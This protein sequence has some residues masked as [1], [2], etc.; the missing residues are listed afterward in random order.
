MTIADRTGLRQ[1]ATPVAF[2]VFNRPEPTA[3][4]FAAIAAVR[5]RQLLIVCDGA[6]DGR[7]DEA[8][9]VAAVRAITTAVDWPCEVRT[10]FAAAN[11][12]CKRRVSSGLDW[13]FGE[14][15]RAIILEDDCLPS[16]AFFAFCEAMLDRYAGDRR[17]HGVSGSD[18]SGSTR[19]AGHYYSNFALMWGWATWRDRWAGYEVDPAMPGDILARLW[20]PRRRAHLFW[21]HVFRRLT[22]GGIDTWD[23]QWILAGWRDSALTVRPTVNLVHNIGF[24]ADATH[25]F[26]GGSDIG[27]MTAWEGDA[28]LLD[29]PPPA[30]AADARRDA[31]DERVWAGISWKAVAAMYLPW[32]SRLKRSLAA[33]RPQAISVRK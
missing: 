26:D 30:V 15:E 1:L 23:Y 31:I 12:G 3:R 2:F 19:P 4:V 27:R 24:G 32:L 11:M 29:A 14:V 21:R 16:R 20:G 22:S 18:F 5:P 28:A 9:R 8:E 10:N 17:I 6:R 7:P 13:V 25:T 33:A